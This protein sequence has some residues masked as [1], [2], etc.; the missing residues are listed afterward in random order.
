MELPQLQSNGRPRGLSTQQAALLR[1]QGKANCVSDP[2]GKTTRQIIASN[3]FTFF[4]LIFAVIAVLLCLVGSYRN[5]TFL[6]VVLGNTLIGIVQ[7]LRAKRVLEK[8]SL[9]NAPHATALRDGMEQVLSAQELVQGDV[10]LLCAGDQ[11]LA[12]ATVLQGSI[13]V[14]E[15]LLTGEADEIEKAPGSGLEQNQ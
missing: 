2:P 10:I 14:N 12:D 7:E 5:L 13:Q 3:T 9:L 4:N 6:P 8:M 15:A 1:E 11:I